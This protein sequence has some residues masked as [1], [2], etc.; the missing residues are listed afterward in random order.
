MESAVGRPR[1]LHLMTRLLV[2]NWR[3]SC[4]VSL[5]NQLRQRT[6]SVM[7]PLIGRNNPFRGWL[8]LRSHL[9]R[10]QQP[11][12]LTLRLL[13]GKPLRF[14]GATPGDP[15][16]HQRRTPRLSRLPPG[17]TIRVGC[18]AMERSRVGVE[19]QIM[20]LETS[21]GKLTLLWV[22]S[23]P[24]KAKVTIRAGCVAMERSPAGVE[25]TARYVTLLRERSHLRERSPLSSQR[26]LCVWDTHRWH[27]HL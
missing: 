22:R 26:K 10:H 27:R 3:R 12:T 14:C 4:G 2:V 24:S 1:R 23:P 21:A 13:A 11:M 17:I 19:L 9:A 20:A 15:Q 6:R 16:H 5:G 8:T 18:A 7:S 25:T